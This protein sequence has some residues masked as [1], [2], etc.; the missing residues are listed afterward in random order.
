[1]SPS[2]TVTVI[3]PTYHEAENVPLLLARLAA[4]RASADL[5]LD[6]VFVDDNS[7]DG[8][9]DA[10]A[11]ENLPWVSLVVRTE[12]RGLS[13]AVLEGF[14]HAR[15]E[16]CIVMD[17]DLSH[18]P[19]K[20]PE[21]LAA[22]DDG[23]D[24]VIGSRYTRGGST[25]E[26]WGMFRA[27]NSRVATWLALPFTRACD[28]MSG[29]FALRR[30]TFDAGGPYS[31]VGYKIGLELLVKCR[32][33]DIREV[34]IHFANRA[35]GQSKLSLQE[36]LRYIQ[37]IRRLFIHRFGDWARFLQFAVVGA[38]GVFVNLAAL[39]VLHIVGVPVKL[40]VA[41]AI[42]VAMLTNFALNRWVTFSYA[43]HDNWV[44]QLFGF[45]A[46]SSLGGAVNYAITMGALSAWPG[47]HDF[48]Q[49][50]SLLGILAGTAFNFVASRYIVFRKV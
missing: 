49:A 43:R 42:F 47:L 23:A 33:R 25:D 26:G 31:P 10:V 30:S 9:A 3:I 4:V 13:T 34:P 36:Q 11:A 6:V 20:I 44:P 27:L 19:E 22:L 35:K 38:S 14:K 24:F 8:I 16:T 29:F 39:T 7:A 41:L 28:P 5:E 15:G 2:G 17:A 1:M 46:A 48:P 18:P 12:E 21:L 50:A 40:S 32:C 45:V 37:H